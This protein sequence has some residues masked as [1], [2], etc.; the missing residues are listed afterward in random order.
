MKVLIQF[1][2]TCI[3]T[4][5]EH[6]L[7]GTMDDIEFV[8]YIHYCMYIIDWLNEKEKNEHSMLPQLILCL[9]S[10]S[11]IDVRQEYLCRTIDQRTTC[12]EQLY[13][14]FFIRLT[15][16]TRERERERDRTVR[17]KKYQV[18]VICLSKRNEQMAIINFYQTLS[19]IVQYYCWCILLVN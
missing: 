3:L 4:R 12:H 13:D 19:S 14:R 16:V 9:L 17:M 6:K 8:E 5:E 2:L 15:R 7:L 18:S 11:S 1:C 10:A